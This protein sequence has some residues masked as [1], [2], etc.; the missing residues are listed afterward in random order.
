MQRW[1]L[2][3]FLLIASVLALW[4]LKDVLKDAF[5]HALLVDALQK[6]A[7]N[8]ALRN[9]PVRIGTLSLR[10]WD[11]VV[12]NLTVHN[13]PGNWHSAP[14]AL[15]IERMHVDF[16]SLA[17][18]LSLMQIPLAAAADSP[19]IVRLGQLVAVQRSN[20]GSEHC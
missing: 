20:L 11:L 12:S 9:S 18:F 8:G 15:H 7:G 19:C 5:V 1:R 16:G 13:V 2:L 3:V 4:L 10:G 14:F 6:R 17:G